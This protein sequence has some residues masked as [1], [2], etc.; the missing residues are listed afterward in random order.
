MNG[1]LSLG[2]VMVSN[3]KVDFFNNAFEK[4]KDVACFHENYVFLDF[5]DKFYKDKGHSLVK[6]NFLK[7]MKF[8]ANE[9]S[10]TV[11]CGRV[12]P[13]DRSV[14]GVRKIWSVMY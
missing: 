13:V 11:V 6:R 2:D 14:L 7:W 10:L 8:C 5:W 4:R 1:K 3:S 9:N 12:D